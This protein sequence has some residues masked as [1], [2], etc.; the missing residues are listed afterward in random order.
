MKKTAFFFLVCLLWQMLP[1]TA[2]INVHHVNKTSGAPARDGVFYS[3]PRTTLKI[4]VV[5]RVEEKIKGPYSEYAEKYLG[6]E[7]AIN[8][9]YTTYFMEDVN[10]SSFNGPD[11]EQLYFIEAADRGSKDF[12]TLNVALDQHGY[13]VSAGTAGNTQPPAGTENR[14]VV[15]YELPSEKGGTSFLPD[16]RIETTQDTIIRRVA[17]D[18]S[19]TEQYFFRTRITGKTT[20]EMALT[21]LDKIE[22][23]RE[24]RYKLLTGFQ[25]TAYQAGTIRYMDQK[26]EKLEN[27]YLDLFRGKTLTTWEHHTYY[28][29]PRDGDDD[30]STLFRF[31]SGTG[32]MQGRSGSGTD[33]R[34][35]LEPS[36]NQKAASEFPSPKNSEVPQKGI[37]YRIPG[38]A[39]VKIEMDSDELFSGEM[40]VNQFGVVKRLPTGRFNVTFNPETGGIRSVTID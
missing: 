25:E 9:D 27:E 4:D 23:L 35:V 32:I 24:A 18:T 26:L 38:F 12:R 6:L 7:N 29:A 5:V 28:Y 30:G 16:R 14:E 15:V 34:L 11:P 3:L 39:G 33:V 1:A 10:V 19:T 21:A 22:Q 31:S 20:E 8:Y 37:A 17:V 13:L 2:Q 40:M 36:G